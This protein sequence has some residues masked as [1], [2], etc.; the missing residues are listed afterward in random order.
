MTKRV[1]VSNEL[2]ASLGEGGEILAGTRP[3][4]RFWT[5]LAVV[6]MKAIRGRTGLS[7]VAFARR[8]TFSSE[9]VRDWEQGRRWPEQAA[10]T[11]LMMMIDKEPEAI[12]R[13]LAAA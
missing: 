2:L 7:Q 11:L 9:A 10:R 13:V 4:T 1:D 5:P 8:F 12:D 6:D 3:A